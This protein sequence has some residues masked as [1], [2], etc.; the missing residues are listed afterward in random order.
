MSTAEACGSIGALF[1][2]NAAKPLALYGMTGGVA[3]D[4]ADC[5]SRVAPF[6]R[7]AVFAGSGPV[8]ESS[9]CTL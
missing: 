3:A 8:R 1:C 7:V 6:V 9:D 2:R 4:V 5:L